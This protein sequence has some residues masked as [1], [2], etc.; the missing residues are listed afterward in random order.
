MKDLGEVCGKCGDRVVQGDGATHYV[1]ADAAHQIK[2]N[3]PG[4]G[5]PTEF[6]C[7]HPDGS[8]TLTCRQDHPQ[9]VKRTP[10]KG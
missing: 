10:M 5:A 7:V 1:N 4:C 8:E 6:Y 2:C 9:T 3:V